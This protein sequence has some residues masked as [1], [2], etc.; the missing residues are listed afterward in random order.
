MRTLEIKRDELASVQNDIAAVERALS[1]IG[2]DGEL[3]QPRK[4][5]LKDIR[6]ELS[7][8]ILDELRKAGPLTSRE[9]AIKLA[10]VEGKNPDDKK[11]IT[12]IVARVS[13]A[14]T[15]LVDKGSV[16]RLKTVGVRESRYEIAASPVS[17]EETKSRR[18]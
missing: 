1:V 15:G 18:N 6:R 8:F 5:V 9:L 11:V 14:I 4:R 7:R 13:K 16:S 10:T 3:D 2:Y 17:A 12:D